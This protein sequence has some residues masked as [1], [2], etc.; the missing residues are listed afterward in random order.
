MRSYDSLSIDSTSLFS[1]LTSLLRTYGP[2][3]YNFDSIVSS[4]NLSC[5]TKLVP[6]LCLNNYS[7]ASKQSESVIN[8][9]SRDN[10]KPNKRK[11]QIHINIYESTAVE[12]AY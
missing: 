11:E 1:L 3:F 6:A 7:R 2:G 4:D 8:Y 9:Q 5:L 12:T 10:K